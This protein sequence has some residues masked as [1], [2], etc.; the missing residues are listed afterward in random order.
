M[1]PRVRIVNRSKEEIQGFSKI[2]DSVEIRRYLNRAIESSAKVDVRLPGDEI[3]FGSQIL[4]SSKPDKSLRIRVPEAAKIDPKKNPEGGAMVIAFLRGQVL[5]C[6]QADRAEWKDKNTLEVFSPWKIFRLQRRKEP[7]FEIL[8]A[9]EIYV[10]METLESGRK[11]IHRRV[12][13]LSTNGMGFHVATAREAALFK[14]GLFL[15]K[16]ELMLEGRQIFL[17]ARVQGIKTIVNDS[18]VSGVKIGVEFIRIGPVDS[19]FIA[20]YVARSLAQL[21]M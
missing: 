8:G 9:Y 19:N 13:D 15:R 6:I 12:L 5:L 10:S 2:E 3:Q 18:R 21:Y 7:R 4:E 17:D 11:R 20:S 1:A 14:K 16:V